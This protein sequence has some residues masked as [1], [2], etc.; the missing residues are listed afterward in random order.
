MQNLTKTLLP[1]C[2]FLLPAPAQAGTLG[3]E[4]SG[5]HTDTGRARIVLLAGT[6]GYHDLIPAYR[7]T[8]V[9]I[10]DGVARWHADDIAP[11]AY[12]LIAH[13]DRN[14]NDDLDRPVLTLP[15]EPYGFSNGA[16]TSF[17]LPDWQQV[18]FDITAAPTHQ[19]IHMRMNAF[20]VFARMLA[21]GAPALVLILGALA[22][23]R[24][25]RKRSPQIS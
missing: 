17:G 7:I 22:V 2:L 20:A 10:R 1:L 19:H 23:I 16:W 18:R 6:A 11:G 8:S 3:V 4:M 5:F 12:A 14:G 21:V 9:P 24:L 25:R 13:H 15:L